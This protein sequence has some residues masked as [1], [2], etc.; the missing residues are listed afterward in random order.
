MSVTYIF[1]F[2][3]VLT[4]SHG[5]SGCCNLANVF[6]WYHENAQNCFDWNFIF[7][8]RDQYLFGLANYTLIVLNI[9][10]SYTLSMS[11]SIYNTCFLIWSHQPDHWSTLYVLGL[12]MLG[13]LATLRGHFWGYK[14]LSCTHFISVSWVSCW[15]VDLTDFRS[16][17]STSL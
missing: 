12:L 6:F 1:V 13:N 2:V 7:H 5:L 8:M 17:L 15:V 10:I 11:S 14:W 9:M 4:F 16:F 3:C